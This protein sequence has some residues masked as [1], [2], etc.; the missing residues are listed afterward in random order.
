VNRLCVFAGSSP[1]T[2]G[3]YRQAAVDLGGSLAARGI[4]LVYGGARVGLMGALADAALQ[5]GG[6]VIGVMP[7]ALVAKEVAHTGLSELKVVSS[8]HERKQLM[9]DLADGFIAL[10]G[11]LGTLEELAE[12][13]T[14]AQLGLH[15]KPVGLVN[16]EGYYA[17]LIEFLDHSVGERFLAPVHRSLL[18]VAETPERLLGLMASHRPQAAE[19]W[20]DREMS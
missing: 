9:A 5:S 8:M 6:E 19:K 13:L 1:G 4:G 15:L 20:L 7:R 17:R 16:V 18:L 2:R 10:P 14:W 11:G 3:E 12:I